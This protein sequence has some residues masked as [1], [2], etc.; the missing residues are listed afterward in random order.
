M[1]ALVVEDNRIERVLLARLLQDRGWE[2]VEA[3]TGR[4]ALERLGEMTPDLIISDGMMPDMDGYQLLREVRKEPGDGAAFIFYTGIFTGGP[5]RELALALGADAFIEKSRPPSELVEEISCLM[6]QKCSLSC[7]ICL[8]EETYLR[9]Y[10]AIMVQ[11]LQQKLEEME[12]E[13]FHRKESEKKILKLRRGLQDVL[14]VESELATRESLP[15]PLSEA[16]PKELQEISLIGG[17]DAAFNRLDQ[18]VHSYHVEQASPLHDEIESFLRGIASSS[19]NLR[20]V[21]HDIV[22]AIGVQRKEASQHIRRMQAFVKLLVEATHEEVSAEAIRSNTEQVRLLLGDVF[23]LLKVA[24]VELKKD[25]VDLSALVRRVSEE[26]GE[27]DPERNVVTTVENGCVVSADPH[28]M[29][30]IMENLLDNAWKF[31]RGLGKPQI[32]FGS[33]NE[34]DG[35][36][37][38]YLRDN[39]VGFD[40]GRDEEIFRPFTRLHPETYGGT[41]VGLAIVKTILARHG[42]A[43]WAVG[44]PHQGA[45]FYFSLPLS[46]TLH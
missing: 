31:T 7:R 9:R 40:P 28:M 8:T 29:R 36:T 19:K 24:T 15:L 1:K 33:R 11:K 44:T 39:G 42:G 4:E 5:E 35:T 43:C 30:I 38:F 2:T 16:L 32:Q 17:I 45:T 14:A 25:I 26:L 41:G 13:R 10:G 6:E 3:A 37:S 23:D 22:S 46:D 18:A 20:K 12:K 27:R 34:R 21:A